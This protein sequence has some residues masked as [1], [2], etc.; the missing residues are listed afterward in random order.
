MEHFETGNFAKSE[1]GWDTNNM[2]GFLLQSICHTI[3]LV[4]AWEHELLYLSICQRYFILGTQV[5][6]LHLVNL[7][8]TLD[9]CLYV[10]KLLYSWPSDFLYQFV[11]VC[12]YV[13]LMIMKTRPNFKA[14]THSN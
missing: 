5:I 14:I 8:E 9:Y 10:N 1:L 2:D 6:K 4:S 11:L 12:T 7:E 13:H 3:Y